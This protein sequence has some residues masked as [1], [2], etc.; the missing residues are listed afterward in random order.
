MVAKIRKIVGI[1][2]YEATNT[3]GEALKTFALGSCV[4]IIFLDPNTHTV[5]LA[6]IALPDSGIDKKRAEDMPAYFADTGIPALLKRMADLG[7]IPKGAGFIV[8]L[9]GGANVMDHQGQ[10]NIGKRNLLAIK[11]FLWQLRMGAI[12]EDTGGSISR[13]VEVDVDTGTVR[14]STSNGDT[15]EI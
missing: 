3:P 10:F 9:V 5:S 6:H 11:K 4:A 15:W 13:T 2:E 8:K 1:G 12:V 14:I 7:S